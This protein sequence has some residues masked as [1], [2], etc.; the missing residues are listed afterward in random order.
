[1]KGEV[2][3]SGRER[4]DIRRQSATLAHTND[5]DP[6]AGLSE[7][8]EKL[9]TNEL[10]VDDDAEPDYELEQLDLQSKPK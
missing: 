7:D 6:F 5:E 4:E 9:E 1:M 3:A 10:V 2:V 8:E